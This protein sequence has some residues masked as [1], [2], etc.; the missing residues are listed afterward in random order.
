VS[1]T[2]IIKNSTDAVKWGTTAKDIPES[3]DFLLKGNL[4]QINRPVLVLISNGK[5]S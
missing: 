2:T 4:I 1:T 5:R 3:F